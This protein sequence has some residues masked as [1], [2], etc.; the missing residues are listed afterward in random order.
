MRKFL[1]VLLCCLFL[2]FT[3]S[4]CGS[5]ISFTWLVDAV[6]ANLD[7]QLTTQGSDL[8]AIY[9]LYSGLVRLDADDEPQPECAESWDISADS[10]TYT[11]HLKP[12]LAYEKLKHH[13]KE[14]FLT[15]HDFV[16]AFQRV[17]QKDTKSPY[18]AEFS[19]IQNSQQVLSGTLSPEMLGVH[20]PDDSTVVFQL[21]HPD[22]Q[23]LK[24]LSLPGAM[25]CNQEFF[26][27]T[28]GAYG[29]SAHGSISS[30]ILANGPFHLYNW[31]EN[32][33]FL[34][35]NAQG[36]RITSLRIVL[37]ETGS[38][39]VSSG[40]EAEPPLTGAALLNADKASAALSEDFE[41]NTFQAFPYTATTWALTFNCEN[42]LLAQPQLRHALAAAALNTALDIPDGSQPAQGLIPPALSVDGRSYREAAGNLLPQFEDPV[43]LCRQ[44]LAAAGAARLSDISIIFPE[45]MDIRPLA[46][47]LN[48][49]WQ[50]Q[51]NPF[52]AFFPIKELPMDEFS[53]RLT[54]G[55]YQIAL[56]PF[57]PIKDNPAE[58]LQ[59][60]SIANPTDPTAQIIE[61]LKR[62]AHWDLEQLMDLEQKIL[63]E[64]TVVPLWYQSK[65][66]LV[67]PNIKGLVFRPFG[68]VLDLTWAEASK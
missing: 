63:A 66:L 6:P 56:V 60:V 30:N 28:R 38:E 64:A 25:P 43:S 48:Q 46:E 23:F 54:S 11:F 61:P 33:L 31:N 21:E 1:A 13:E 55:D 7:P 68:P 22:P 39:P 62:T 27:S 49:Q 8:V 19:A 2:V 40:E 41:S 37:N 47:S 16:F 42:P 14:Y 32:G 35:R 67:Q 50:K 26:E 34:R 10:L 17:F 53:K 44:G 18:T 58:I 45:G 12:G 51:L 29:L 59:Q 36:S 15:A 24:K 65:S 57:S 3:L 9:N 20:A 52:S 5:Q 4:G